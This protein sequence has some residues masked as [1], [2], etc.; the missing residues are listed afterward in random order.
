MI[1]QWA[2]RNGWTPWHLIGAVAL[3][4]L[5][6]L[7]MFR[8]WADIV[9]IAWRDDEQS[10]IFLVPVIVAWL[11]WVR[12]GRLTRCS[13][14]SGWLGALMVAAGFAANWYGL[15]EVHDGL[16]HGGAVLLLA[17]AF[18][19]VA[20]QEVLYR[21]LPAFLVL[22]FLIPVPGVVRQ[23]IALPLQTGTAYLTQHILLLFDVDVIRSNNLLVVNGEAITIAEAC[24][25]MRMVFALFLVSFGF[26]Y[27]TALRP[28]VRIVVVALSPLT[29]LLCN[30]IR[31][32]AT[33]WVY[34][35]ELS[36]DAKMNFHDYTGWVMLFVAL[37]LLMG[38]VRVFRW[39]LLPV[40]PYP[41]AYEYG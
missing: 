37:L 8:D 13:P 34:G 14:T 23:S 38:V 20:G 33:A 29:A 28:Y 5:A 32:V 21:M 17:G 16:R 31:T 39:A 18:I 12:R 1:P 11:V 15:V 7:A 26:A 10:H 25:G 27:G 30:V 40:T 22:A 2:K 4:V 6:V 9:Y 41:L 19:A 3:P 36:D 24:N 35:L